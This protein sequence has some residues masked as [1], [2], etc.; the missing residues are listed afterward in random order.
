MLGNER[1]KFDTW[2]SILQK[3][4]DLNNMNS[5]RY[6]SSL[7]HS[8]MVWDERLY[9]KQFLLNSKVRMKELA[10]IL[11]QWIHSEPNVFSLSTEDYR[12]RSARWLLE[13]AN[14]PEHEWDFSI[15]TDFDDN[16]D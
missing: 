15:R 4:I 7:L 12:K 6:L 13:K 2:N 10:E 3:I 11:V 1:K 9:R 5:K 8:V 16:L 14:V